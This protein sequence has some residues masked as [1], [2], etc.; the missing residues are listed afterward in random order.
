M[1]VCDPPVFASAG[2]GAT[3][4]VEKE[5]YTLALQVH[6]LLGPEGVALFANNHS[7]GSSKKYLA[8]LE[9]I[10]G[11]VTALKP[12]FDF[13]AIAGESEHVRIYWC[14]M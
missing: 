6:A 7:A 3:F 1:I 9:D 2:K 5:W 4:A 8:E 13:P 11:K 10:F 12:P 14:E